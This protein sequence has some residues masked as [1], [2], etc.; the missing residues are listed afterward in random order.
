MDE[1]NLRLETSGGQVSIKKAGSSVIGRGD[2]NFSSMILPHEIS[3][4]ASV[5]AP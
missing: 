2:V 4:L 1:I 5:S 3:S